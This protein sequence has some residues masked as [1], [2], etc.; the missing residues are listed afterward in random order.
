MIRRVGITGTHH[1]GTPA[2]LHSLRTFL[3]D[4]KPS[5][6]DQGDCIGV[7]AEAALMAHAMGI[8]IVSHP[9]TNS[10]RRAFCHADEFREPKAYI[11]RDQDI[12]NE[13]DM[14]IGVP[15]T[16]HEVLRSGTWAT[17]R[18]AKK[19]NK[20]IYLIIPNGELLLFNKG[21]TI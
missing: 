21:K 19:V 8:W 6:L 3:T 14:L 20:I 18:Y 1:G 15:Y 7:D 12:V 10:W 17:I 9:P 2:Q 11:K 5:R 13:T 16:S 4:L